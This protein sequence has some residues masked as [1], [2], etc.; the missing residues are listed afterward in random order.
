MG[1]ENCGREQRAKTTRANNRA[2]PLLS[3]TY[4][5]TMDAAASKWDAVRG[6][7]TARAAR[8]DIARQSWNW[9]WMIALTLTTLW[10]LRWAQLRFVEW[11]ASVLRRSVVS[12]HLMDDANEFLCREN[13]RRYGI[14]D[15]DDRPFHIAYN[16]AAAARRQR[17]LE[18]RA[19]LQEQEELQQVTYP[20]PASQPSML[21]GP[22]PVSRERHHSQPHLERSSSVQIQPLLGTHASY[23]ALRR[24]ELHVQQPYVALYPP[25]C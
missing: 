14:P 21:Q 3:P 18:K 20:D 10:A 15:D 9:P 17:E 16:A 7:S 25:H 8:Q 5:R 19:Q 13:R 24:R 23:G 12:L 1:Q 2:L 4:A 11:R 22:A 6:T